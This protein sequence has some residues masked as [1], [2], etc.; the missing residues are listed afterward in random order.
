MKSTAASMQND[1]K[2][3]A[4]DCALVPEASM[5]KVLVSLAQYE[6]T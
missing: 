6:G 1:D 2:E 5:R 4:G 3:D